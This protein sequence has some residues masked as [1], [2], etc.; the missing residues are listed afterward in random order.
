MHLKIY[1]LLRRGIP[2]Y[3]VAFKYTMKFLG[4]FYITTHTL[5]FWVQRL[6]VSQNWGVLTK[7]L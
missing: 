5:K 4:V 1:P 6:R 2:Q 3:K 7:H